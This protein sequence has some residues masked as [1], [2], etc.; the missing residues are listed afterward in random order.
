MLYVV[1]KT[2]TQT[3]WRPLNFTQVICC[4]WC[5]CMKTNYLEMVKGKTNTYS[6]QEDYGHRAS[7][8]NAVQ[9]MRFRFDD[10]IDGA[11][12]WHLPSST[13]PTNCTC[14]CI[15]HS[16]MQQLQNYAGLFKSSHSIYTLT[17]HAPQL[18][19]FPSRPMSP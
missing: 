10:L 9:I 13:T 2:H 16:T 7:S 18:M 4:C 8:T 17:L 6:F 5:L 11:L 1:Y 3:T 15:A 12:G 14:V 19:Q